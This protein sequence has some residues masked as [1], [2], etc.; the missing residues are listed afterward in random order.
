MSNNPHQ[1]DKEQRLWED[2][3]RL[4]YENSRFADARSRAN[5]H[6]RLTTELAKISRKTYLPAYRATL[7]VIQDSRPNDQGEYPELL[8]PLPFT[9][10]FPPATPADVKADHSASIEAWITGERYLKHLVGDDEDERKAY[11][12]NLHAE[13]I[14]VVRRR[15]S[16]GLAYITQTEEHKMQNEDDL[17]TL[18]RRILHARDLLPTPAPVPAPAPVKV[19]GKSQGPLVAIAILVGLA[20]VSGYAVATRPV[21]KPH[22]KRHRRRRRRK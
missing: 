18:K 16:K 13:E 2:I 1:H 11:V 20:T 3:L 14:P 12:A 7:R 21:Q 17:A 9:G 15:I 19:P 6:E 10:D 22:K 5:T 4:Y 8:L